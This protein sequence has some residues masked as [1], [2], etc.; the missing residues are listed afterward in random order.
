MANKTYHIV[1]TVLKYY[2]EIIETEEKLIPLTHIYMY[3]LQ[4]TSI[5]KWQD[6]KST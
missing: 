5:K 4:G 6:N 3:T 2:Q 1:R